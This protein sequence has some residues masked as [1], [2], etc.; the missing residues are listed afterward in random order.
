MPIPFP[1]YFFNQKEGA[2]TGIQNHSLYL[3]HYSDSD[4][5][6]VVYLHVLTQTKNVDAPALIA[7]TWI[8]CNPESIC[9]TLATI[10]R[11]RL[12]ISNWESF[13]TSPSLPCGLHSCWH[14]FQSWIIYR[15]SLKSNGSFTLHGTGNGTGTGTGM[16]TIENNGYLSL[17]LSLCSV[18]S[19]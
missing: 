8:S 16:G 7:C 12:D 2:S 18:N 17:S 9:L 1:T 6:F 5:C 19:I 11:F 4:F 3:M 15:L 13:R 14:T 10:S